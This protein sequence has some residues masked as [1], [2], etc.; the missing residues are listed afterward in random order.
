V[1]K[2]A[3]IWNRVKFANRKAELI[4]QRRKALKNEDMA[5]FRQAHFDMC[6]ADE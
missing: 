5:G 4:D 6:S 1:Y 2:T 3:L